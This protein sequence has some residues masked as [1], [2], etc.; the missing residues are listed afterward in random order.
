VI[1]SEKAYDAFSKIIN[2][3]HDLN[4]IAYLA[5][6]KHFNKTNSPFLSFPSEGYTLSLDFPK[7]KS[8]DATVKVLNQLTV[9]YGGK[10]YL[11]KDSMLE[12][13]QF[14][15]MYDKNSFRDVLKLYNS[16]E[17]FASDLSKRVKI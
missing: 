13:E 7:N 10:I 9:K 11:A 1:P 5:V 4:D 15:K 8:N 16:Y 12:P 14:E 2:T 3:L 6:I 17:C